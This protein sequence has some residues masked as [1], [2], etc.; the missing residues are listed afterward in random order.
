MGALFPYN[1]VSGPSRQNPKMHATWEKGWGNPN[2]NNITPKDNNWE[3]RPT[4]HG[5]SNAEAKERTR[6]TS[7][8]LTPAMEKEPFSSLPLRK[9]NGIRAR[10]KEFRKRK[11]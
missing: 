10:N 1:G 8:M 7:T 9:T 11:S 2:Q 6:R 4:Q 3:A 5:Q